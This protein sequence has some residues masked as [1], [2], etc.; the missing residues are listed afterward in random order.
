MGARRGG[1]GKSKRDQLQSNCTVVAGGD[2]GWL[3]SE[4]GGS[5]E[6][7]SGSGWRLKAEQSGLTGGQYAEWERK[8][9]VRNDGI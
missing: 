7:G 9:R 3:R 5:G 8:G 2:G 1:S 6:K 4:R